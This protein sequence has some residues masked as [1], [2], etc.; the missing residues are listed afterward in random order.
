MS[1]ATTDTHPYPARGRSP[2]RVC[3]TAEAGGE[4]PL[5]AALLPSAAAAVQGPDHLAAAP[6]PVTRRLASMFVRPRRAT[7]TG[8]LTC[9]FSFAGALDRGR[10]I[11]PCDLWVATTTRSHRGG[12]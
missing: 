3:S 2:R 10:R 5:V 7:G 11:G 4:R 1:H 8:L 12:R 6:E 9:A